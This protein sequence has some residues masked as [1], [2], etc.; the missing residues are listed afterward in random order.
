M[1]LSFETYMD[2]VKTH[3]PVSK[4]AELQ[5]SKGDASLQSSRGGF[6]PKI[7]TDI[8]QKYY[9]GSQ[10]Y[11]LVNAGLK[12]PTWMGIELQAG[13]EQNQGLYL[14]PE[15]TTP[16]DGLMYAGI[17]IPIGQGLFIDKRR[18]ELQ[19]AKNF[20]E[21]SELE[22]QIM[23]ND[24][25]YES[26]QAYWEWFIAH[27]KLLVFEEAYELAEDRY[28]AVKR[29]A[30]LGDLPP[31][32]TLEAG[33]QL[34]NRELS[35]QQARL[36]FE[37]ATE[38]LSLY[39]WVDG[40]VPLE[41]SEG[42][43]P[44]TKD[45]ITDYSL[46]GGLLSELDTF[47]SNHPELQQY[48]FKVEQMEIDKRLKKEQLKPVVNLK[49]NALSRPINGNPF[50]SYNTNNYTW[51]LEFRFPVFLR[52]ERGNVKLADL[53]IQDAEFE[54]ATKQAGIEI[55]TNMAINLWTTTIEQINLYN[56]TVR[57]Y[58]GLLDGERKMFNAGE[59]SLFMVNS[60]EAGYIQ[61]QL[62]LIELIAKNRKAKLSANFALGLLAE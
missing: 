48:Q 22:Q 28:L 62:K 10:Y 29:G 46:E 13:Y 27:S 12:I 35:L 39:L 37:N 24:L 4:Q 45:S 55:K 19:K 30:A 42:T 20:Q 47:I 5:I 6:D 1:V 14:N 15:N 53:K 9:E 31:I 17:S 41:T 40:I 43:I 7:F 61:A 18:A 52:K 58:Y 16:V 34:Q 50:T 54:L 49:Y 3:H 11:S 38:M 21:I 2:I 36:D 60:R 57:D 32:D 56:Q 59:S 25:L 8:G 33:I 26:G 23:L 44:V 51:G